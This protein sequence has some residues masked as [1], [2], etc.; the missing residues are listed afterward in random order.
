MTIA[1]S[2]DLSGVTVA[3]LVRVSARVMVEPS[4]GE[5]TDW[6]RS[7][8][9]FTNMATHLDHDST[10][11]PDPAAIQAE[12]RG[13]WAIV[14]RALAATACDARFADGTLWESLLRLYDTCM[15]TSRR[16][17]SAIAGPRFDG[18]GYDADITLPLDPE[19]PRILTGVADRVP[20]EPLGIALASL[21][22][23]CLLSQAAQALNSQRLHSAG[24]ILPA[25]GA[26]AVASM[27]GH[28]AITSADIALHTTI[29]EQ[30][31]PRMGRLLIYRNITSNMGRR[32]RDVLADLDD[33]DVLGGEHGRDFAL[34]VATH[35][36]SG[37]LPQ[38]AAVRHHQSLTWMGATFKRIAA[39]FER[40]EDAYFET[41]EATR[42][43]RHF[44]DLGGTA[45]SLDEYHRGDIPSAMV[46]PGFPD[47]ALIDLRETV[48]TLHAGA[49]PAA[50]D[51]Y[52][53]GYLLV[54]DVLTGYAE[55]TTPSD[56]RDALMF[57]A[58]TA[59]RHAF[60]VLDEVGRTGMLAVAR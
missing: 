19:A 46:A 29:E 16:A 52:I 33:D 1:H 15:D 59:E 34:S 3:D 53:D 2:D 42:L 17:P 41:L 47:L 13:A 6:E 10:W 12:P 30:A 48:S 23:A 60:A 43:A 32:L 7:E 21:A 55:R 39:A 57:T 50:I 27:F 58:R 56:D 4:D 36:A 40:E 18:Y 31:T 22:R 24:S 28:E 44:T 5:H 9:L 20:Y 51:A 37:E 35:L 11:L 49:R 8:R 54:A 38:S 14:S 45:E 26:S 25:R